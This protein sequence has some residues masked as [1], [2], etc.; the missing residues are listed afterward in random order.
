MDR[1]DRYFEGSDESPVVLLSLFEKYEYDEVIDS[2]AISPYAK[3]AEKELEDF[4]DYK[5]KVYLQT[6][7][8]KISTW[9]YLLYG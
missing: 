3:D 5:L 2:V 9:R 8:P 7:S 4:N 6:F 1:I